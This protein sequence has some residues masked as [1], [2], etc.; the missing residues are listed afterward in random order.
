MSRMRGL[1][2]VDVEVREKLV[3]ILLISCCWGSVLCFIRRIPFTLLLLPF[4]LLAWL[5][6]LSWCWPSGCT[7]GRCCFS[8]LV[9][10]LR[11]C[12][13]LDKALALGMDVFVRVTLPCADRRG[14]MLLFA[15]EYWQEGMNLSM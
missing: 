8:F 9:G 12:M 11:R 7:A 10:I 5:A 13:C 6:L 1:Y 2:Q 15:E 4:P 3:Q 14:Q